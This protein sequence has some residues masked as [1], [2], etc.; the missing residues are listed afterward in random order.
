MFSSEYFERISVSPGSV[1]ATLLVGLVIY[2]LTVVLREIIGYIN[3]RKTF[4]GLPEPGKRHWL[5]GHLHLVSILIV[6]PP[7]HIDTYCICYK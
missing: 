6:L 5:Y 4:S 2:I 3:L 7:I 1:T